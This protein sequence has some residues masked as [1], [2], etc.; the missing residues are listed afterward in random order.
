MAHAESPNALDGNASD[1]TYQ[2]ENEERGEVEDE[3]GADDEVEEV[4]VRESHG[5]G[6]VGERSPPYGSKGWEG[7]RDAYHGGWIQG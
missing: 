3:E 5:E 4:V 6:C 1:D 2:G 7:R